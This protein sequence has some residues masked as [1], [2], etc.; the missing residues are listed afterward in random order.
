ME[1]G[2][3]EVE[4]FVRDRG[5]GFD[6]DGVD[7]D[8]QG[9]ARSIKSRVERA[10]GQARIDST[11]GRGTNIRLIMPRPTTHSDADTDGHDDPQ[12]VT[13]EATHTDEAIDHGKAR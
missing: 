8:R 11:P 10:G 9:L 13:H 3:E 12:D 7:P 1:V 4:V 2:D 5:V 6:R